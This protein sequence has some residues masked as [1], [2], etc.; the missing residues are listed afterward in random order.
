MAR[1]KKSARRS[2][3][4]SPYQPGAGDA[5]KPG[6]SETN[7]PAAPAQAEPVN[8]T[9]PTLL[10]I[11][12]VTVGL[13][14]AVVSCSEDDADDDPGVTVQRASYASLA[15]CEADWETP[16]DCESVPMENTRNPYSSSLASSGGEGASSADATGSGGGSHGYAR[17][18]GPFYTQSGTVYHANGTQTYRDMSSGPVQPVRAYDSNGAMSSG[19]WA[20][21]T[22][23]AM[24][25]EEATVRRSSLSGGR[26]MGLS[27]RSTAVARAPAVSRGGFT[28]GRGSGRSG[29]G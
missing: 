17:W 28:G 14:T 26:S 29:G 19:G 23:N 13:T 7:K 21:G 3:Y 12:A 18:Y 2:R 1:K 24:M 9:V 6:V 8:I 10:I 22:P 27:M 11:G 16:N 15:D 5:H 4:G 25:V 20:R